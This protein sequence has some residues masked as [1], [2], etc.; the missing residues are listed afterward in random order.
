MTVLNRTPE[1]IAEDAA[2]QEAAADRLRPLVT[3]SVAVAH[4]KNAVGVINGMMMSKKI[5]YE[6]LAEAQ[7]WKGEF[8]EA[9]ETLTLSESVN[10]TKRKE[11]TAYFDALELIGF[12]CNCEP[13]Q[14]RMPGSAKGEPTPA[15]RE[16]QRVFVA[17]IQQ[18]VAFIKC[19]R[20]NQL[21]A[22][23]V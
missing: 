12:I 7:F 21:Y 1:E 4:Y 14:I 10:Q 9:I 11:Y 19:E 18:E 8:K 17:K 13:I 2:A 16:I 22:Q 20:C 6:R 15:R 3:D 5:D 23:T